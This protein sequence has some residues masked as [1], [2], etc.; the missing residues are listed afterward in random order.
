MLSLRPEEIPE[1]LTT[2][3]GE[4]Q[5]QLR[6]GR[7]WVSLWYSH[8]TSAYIAEEAQTWCS[9]SY[10]ELLVIVAALGQLQQKHPCVNQGEYQ[11][12]ILWREQRMQNTISFFPITVSLY[13]EKALTKED[14]LCKLFPHLLSI[15]YIWRNVSFPLH[16]IMT[17]IR[18]F[19]KAINLACCKQAMHL[20]F[21]FMDLRLSSGCPCWQK[22]RTVWSVDFKSSMFLA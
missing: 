20:Q 18:S 7:N 14:I 10:E 21:H 9:Y 22:E 3:L 11:H 15:S 5:C 16:F 6:Q 19:L 8:V 13:S 17:D 4:L 1:R 12:L 2:Q